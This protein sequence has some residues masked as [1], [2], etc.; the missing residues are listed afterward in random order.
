M[1]RNIWQPKHLLRFDVSR[2]I[3]TCCSNAHL[4]Y[5]HTIRELTFLPVLCSKGAAGLIR[6]PIDLRSC[7]RR[8]TSCASSLHWAVGIG[9][10]REPHLR[11]PQSPVE[12]GQRDAERRYHFGLLADDGHGDGGAL[13]QSLLLADLLLYGERVLQ[14][15]PV[16]ALA[17]PAAQL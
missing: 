5:R 9:F 1:K 2:T 16:D 17:V 8:R 7:R 15:G 10:R 11:H 6:E 12:G 13:L 4:V 3:H 14:A